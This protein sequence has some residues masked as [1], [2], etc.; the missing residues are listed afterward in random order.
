M[1]KTVWPISKLSNWQDNP[2]SITAEAFALLKAKIVKWGQFKPVVI[3]PQGEVL[4]GNMRLR[5]YNELGI[6]DIWVSIVNP[7]TEAEKAELAITDNESSGR[8]DEDK[9]AELIDSLK[10]SIVLTDYQIDL[11]KPINLQELLDKYSPTILDD[12]A[13]PDGYK[14]GFE[15]ITFTLSTQQA[16]LVRQAL[17]KAK[18]KEVLDNLDNENSNGN[19]IS[20]IAELYL[21][22]N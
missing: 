2:R 20:K 1:D 22:G 8:W 7:K 15:Q 3:T 10:D 16:E 13:L 12:I 18:D 11:G 14:S 5:A 19:A 21:N 6:K 4:G 17:A 9:L